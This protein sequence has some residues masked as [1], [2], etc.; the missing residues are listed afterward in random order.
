MI[1][2]F[3]GTREGCSSPQNV[4]LEQWFADNLPTEL[5]VGCCRG[6]DECAFDA[7]R[8]MYDGM[9]DEIRVVG[10]PPYSNALVAACVD[11]CDETLPPKQ[12]LDRNKDIVNACDVLLACPKGPEELCSGTWSTVRYARKQGK[13]VVIIWPDGRVEG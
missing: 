4:A 10:H 6:A 7:A 13:R 12:Y 2:G 11:E 1:L 9:E 5:H 8:I 3:T